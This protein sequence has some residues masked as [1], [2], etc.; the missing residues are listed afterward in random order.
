MTQASFELSGTAERLA[1]QTALSVLA[2]ASIFSTTESV[3]ATTANAPMTSVPHVHADGGDITEGHPVMA[4]ATKSM[5]LTR[6]PAKPSE[7]RT[8]ATPRGL[9]QSLTKCRGQI[10]TNWILRTIAGTPALSDRDDHR[11]AVRSHQAAYLSSTQEGASSFLKALPTS[12][13]FVIG[14][15]DFEV[16]VRTYL[17]LGVLSAFGLSEQDN[18]TCVCSHHNRIAPARL[19]ENHLLLCNKA[20]FNPRHNALQAVMSECIK[21]TK[22]TCELEQHITNPTTG[23]TKDADIVISHPSSLGFGD[24]PLALEICVVNPQSQE[25]HRTSATPKLALNA[26]WAAK[27]AEYEPFVG[28][29]KH[30]FVGL[31]FETFGATH[32]DVYRTLNALGARVGQI[33]PDDAVYTAPSFTSYWAQSL[34]VTLWRENARQ[35]RRL[36]GLVLLEHP[37]L[38]ETHPLRAKTRGIN[39]TA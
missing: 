15:V 4:T 27:R 1:S 32:P 28:K 17:Q 6:L 16:A 19:T 12:E 22:L 20:A 8:F 34:S 14:N 35:I 10:T 25:Y 9:Q 2:Q 21:S 30:S 7:L 5:A 31:I 3:Q 39:A 24:E 37:D 36:M 29:G 38:S 18:Y 33:A 13:K 11:R 23:E 26:L